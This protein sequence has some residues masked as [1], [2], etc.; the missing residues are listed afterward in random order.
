MSS[1]TNQEVDLKLN[2]N[3]ESQ[4]LYF[5]ILAWQVEQ[6]EWENLNALRETD[7]STIITIETNMVQNVSIPAK[8]VVTKPSLL[9]QEEL[10]FERIEVGTDKRGKIEIHNPSKNPIEISAFIAPINFIDSIIDQMLNKSKIL[11][12]K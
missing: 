3:I 4:M 8:S 6:K 11:Y 5:D 2:P 10:I 7:T 9:N 1:G 12:W